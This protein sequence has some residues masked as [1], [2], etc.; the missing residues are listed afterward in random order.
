MQ[1][2]PAPKAKHV[3]APAP[4]ARLRRRHVAAAVG[5]VLI[6]IAP[7]VAT[8]WYMWTQ[9]AD[10]YV[11]TAGFSVRTEDTSSAFELLGGVAELSGSSTKDSEVLFQF[12]QSQDLVGRIDDT[13]DLRTIWSRVPE[14]RD[15][16]FAYRPPGTIEDLTDH[17]KRM[18]TVYVD[19][20]SGLIEV[21]VQAFTP[22]DAVQINQAIY[23][24]SLAMINQLSAIARED[25]T[26]YARADFDT[27]M[28][29]LRLAR[30][31]MT[32]FRN[33]TQIV[34][35]AATIQS[36]MGILTSL[37]TAL[38]T[39]LIEFDILVQSSG[40]DDP[41][42]DRAQDRIDVIEDR[43][44]QERNKFGIGENNTD[45]GTDIA[46]ADLVSA[47][48]ILAVDLEFAETR[49]RAAQA[50]L[51]MAL[52]DAGRQNRYLAAHIRPTMPERS[53]APDR[54]QITG[55]VA[56]FAFL[57]WSVVTLSAYAIRDRR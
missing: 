49:Y 37:Q 23:D 35:P 3:P 12:I 32:E 39:E 56:I 6:V 11:S 36:Q 28:D 29:R 25:T 57:I 38:A 50:A 16:V 1:R 4:R 5:F 46:F 22:Q 10:R 55:L 8:A 19:A 45:E 24:E 30:A 40:R 52:A 2:A 34:D 21:Q 18:V 13:L 51:D 54:V 44:Q 47:Y 33:R 53:D 41:R 20:N 7:I 17:W 9:A 31:S 43:I 15:P 27:A 26:R 48:E 14:E 42:V